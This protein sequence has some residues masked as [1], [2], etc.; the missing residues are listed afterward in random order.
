[1]DCPTAP[2]QSAVRSPTADP[3]APPLSPPNGMT[4]HTT[5]RREAFIRPSMRSGVIA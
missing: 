5:K 3:S 2:T 4:P 1:M